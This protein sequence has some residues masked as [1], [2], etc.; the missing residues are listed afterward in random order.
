MVY[1]I[2]WFVRVQSP[3]VTLQWLQLDSG[4]WFF[5]V[6][7]DSVC[8]YLAENFCIYI[9]QRCWPVIFF[10]G[11]VLI[12]FCYRGDGDF[13]EWLWEHSL[14]FSLLEEFKKNQCKLFCLVDFPCSH[15]ILELFCREFFF[16]YR[17]YFIFSDV[18][19]QIICFSLFS[20]SRLYVLKVCLF[21]LDCPFC[22]QKAM[23]P[24]SSTLAWKIPWMEEPGGLQSMGSWRIGYDWATSLSL[25]T[26]M[27]WRRNGN[28]LQCSCLENPRDGGAWWAAV[29]GVAQSRTPLK[30]LS[31]SS[32]SSYFLTISLISSILKQYK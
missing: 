1:H 25:F 26:F 18:S 20:F 12:W 23:A 24:H 30:R 3:L 21:L 27:H 9:N 19:V 2:D 22:W 11:S 32:S 31:S 17:F 16:Y 7:L 6:F 29:Y 14:L 4:V 10:F 8:Y 13:I 28:P 15:P 5:Y